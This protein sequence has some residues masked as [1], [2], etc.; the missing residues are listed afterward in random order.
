[1]ELESPIDA[2]YVWIGV[3]LISVGFAGV[4]VSLP[5]EAPPDAGTAA[6]AVE[7]VAT[8]SF[9]SSVTYDHQAQEVWIDTRT[10]ALR[11]DGGTARA[12]ISF[13]TMTPVRAHPTSPEKGINITLDTP[14]EE[15]FDDPEAMREWANE[16]EENATT[17]GWRPAQ[18]E[19]RVQKVEW[20]DESVIFVDI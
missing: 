6:N 17:T 14:V 19:L 3:A 13:G 10:I 15:E 8:S 20:G 1:M 18:D 4:A 5:S 9:N 12:T 2:W 16:T 7:D 11:N